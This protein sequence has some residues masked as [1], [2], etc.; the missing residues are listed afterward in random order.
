[1]QCAILAG[2]LGTRL[3]P[4]TKTIPKALVP[5]AGEPFA[6][7][8]LRLLAARGVL[9]VVYCIGFGGEL[10]REAVGDG[11]GFGLSVA[12]VD[13][14][15][16]LRGTAGALR[17]A[18][19][20]GVLD[21]TF[22]VLYGDSYLPIELS[23]V[24]RAFADAGLPALMTVLRNENRWDT[25][26]VRYADGRVLLYEKGGTGADFIDYGLSVLTRSVIE[27]R[28]PPQA[29]LDLAA[30]YRDLSIEDRLAGH[31]VHE[32]FYE[33]GSPE[34]IAALESYLREKEG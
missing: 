23:P 17:L 25:S 8:Q 3:R 9:D 5:V 34:G 18:F 31:E 28:V 22:A 15:S 11:G 16:E 30:I 29:T 14:G 27:E 32:R 19:D 7:Y 2:G 20:E 26:N 21:E 33:V 6:Y 12:Y 10:I 24:W 1:M 13:E 4:I